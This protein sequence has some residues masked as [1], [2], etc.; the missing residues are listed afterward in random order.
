MN[1]TKL[2]IVA[3]TTSYP[4]HDKSTSGIFVK[5]LIDEISKFHNI[6]VITADDNSTKNAGDNITTFRY[7]PKAMQVLSHQPGGIPVAI[8]KSW[9]NRF[10][11]IPFCLSLFISAYFAAKKADLIYANWSLTGL[12]SGIAAKLARKPCV[13]TLRGEDTKRLSTSLASRLLTYLC[14]MFNKKI[15]CVSSDME[16]EIKSLFPDQKSKIQ[17]I[18]NGVADYFFNMARRTPKTGAKLRILCV[19][20]LIPRKDFI[21]V[22]QALAICEQRNRVRL[23]ILGEG[24][25]RKLLENEI[26]KLLL[27]D[28]VKL[29]GACHYATVQQM[30]RD[31]DI[32]VITSLS[33]GRPNVLIEAMASRL[34]IIASRING[35]TELITDDENGILFPPGNRMALAQSLDLM[36]TSDELRE[37]F[38]RQAR[39]TIQMKGLTWKQCAINY[40]DTFLDIKAR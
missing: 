26:R 30:M 15:I 19:G 13:T 20:S 25:E 5:F 27:Y 3:V 29:H 7:A 24:I 34:P 9:T 32:F 33:E 21:T 23:D 40:S 35:I 28:H 16:V 39:N 6:R 10:L 22:I 4:L 1:Q 17:H 31:A 8:A 37:Q 12:I 14:I 11:L 2:N 36:V 38:A 18:P